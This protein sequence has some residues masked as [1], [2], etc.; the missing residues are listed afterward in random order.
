MQIS[1]AVIHHIG[2]YIF[3]KATN[4]KDGI[5]IC[6]RPI[7]SKAP[8]HGYVWAAIQSFSS[9]HFQNLES[10]QYLPRDK[11]KD[12]FEFVDQ[13]LCYFRTANNMS[14][15]YVTCIVYDQSYNYS[16]N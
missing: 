3:S 14:N 2:E 9:N 7:L 15:I 10:S 5:E 1:L 6:S 12:L 4:V 13:E 11:L 16:V 8:L